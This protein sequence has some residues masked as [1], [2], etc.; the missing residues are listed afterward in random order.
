MKDTDQILHSTAIQLKNR[1]NI[2]VIKRGVARMSKFGL[3]I[4]AALT[5]APAIVMA[6]APARHDYMLFALIEAELAEMPNAADKACLAK[7]NQEPYA[8]I[9]CTVPQFDRIEQRLDQSYQAVMATLPKAKKTN[10]ES[11]QGLWLI[12]RD[13]IC[14]ARVGDELN[15][16]SITYDAAIIQCSLAEL[17]RR[18][19][20]VERFHLR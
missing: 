9:A 16:T 4:T 19:L 8:D 15:E 17:Y 1:Y 18:T 3:F 10:L 11:E 14:K 12:T 6:K 2:H 5:I 13:A 20:W 7:A